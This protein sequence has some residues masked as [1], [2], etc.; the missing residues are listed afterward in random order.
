MKDDEF[1]DLSEKLR[2][3]WEEMDGEEFLRRHSS[4]QSPDADIL[5]IEDWRSRGLPPP[6]KLLGEW[7]TTTSRI[8]LTADTG[9]GKT[10]LCMA[11]AGNMAAGVD[12]LHWRAHRLA[13]V[14]YIDGEMSRRL[15]QRRI[16]DLV[17]RLGFEPDQLLL[18]SSE[19][20]EN[21]A[22]LNTPE[23]M[24]WLN[25][26]LGRIGDKVDFIFFDNIMALIQ[27]DQKDEIGW[28]AVLPLVNSLT[29]RG[30]GQ[31]WVHHT[32]HNASRGYGTKTREW[33]MDTVVHLMA[34]ER[35]D[36]DICFQFEFRKARERTPETRNDYQ[37]VT[38]A[39]V[40][41]R[42]VGT[43]GIS[44]EKLRPQDARMLE[45][46]DKLVKDGKAVQLDAGYWAVQTADWQTVCVDGG[47][48]KS[49]DVFRARKCQLVIGKY[50]GC[51]KERSWRL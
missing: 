40:E 21:F 48:T 26:L 32:G 43:V 7:L 38:I 24:A 44:R 12:F 28:T 30:I 17:R 50:I 51:D 33:R 22:P 25:D 46:F 23:G 47:I 27:G 2:G 14:L 10:N 5:R 31:L 42:W 16:E 8:L 11:I 6:D 13:K 19:D 20:V 18:L 39:L 29:K 49:A 34:V 36:T 15:Y 9:L 35:A 4:S 3:E 45:E 1:E 37:D 41:D